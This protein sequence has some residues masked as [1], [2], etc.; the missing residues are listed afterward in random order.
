MILKPNEKIVL[1][2]KKYSITQK[3]LSRNTLSPSTLCSI[4]KGKFKL[5][6]DNAKALIS[7]FHEIFNEKNIEA[8]ISL[9]WLY[10]DTSTQIKNKVNKL[11][12]DLYSNYEEVES[13]AMKLIDNSSVHKELEK[14]LFAIGCYHH[15]NN[16]YVKSKKY[17]E[18]SLR[19]QMILEDYE[20]LEVTLQFLSRIN[21]FLDKHEDTVKLYCEH[22]TRISNRSKALKGM[23]IYNFALAFQCLNKHSFAIEHY[24]I[25]AKYPINNRLM[26]FSKLNKGVAL[27]NI[28][29]Y[30]QAI[31]TF[32]SLAKEASDPELKKKAYA[33]VVSCARISDN[34][35]MC[36]LAIDTLE[37]FLSTLDSF[38]GYQTY[39]TLALGYLYIKDKDNAIKYL[40]LEAYQK[41]DIGNNNFHIERYLDSIEKLLHLYTRRDIAKLKKLLGIIKKIPLDIINYEFIFFAIKR[42]NDFYLLEE[43][44]SLVNKFYN[45]ARNK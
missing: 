32:K 39:Y 15:L 25:A 28:N 27:Q 10:E 6:E 16:D 36:K 8:H 2:R 21:Y 41:A 23:I 24:N 19:Y 14:L 4:E 7:R 22:Y 45:K 13:E 12:K 17:L 20:Y 35:I 9:S 42:Y 29:E 3:E 26:F 38:V 30:D 33:N 40:E 44:S 37:D 5:S 43:S 34:F 1:L 31:N 18:H 11:I